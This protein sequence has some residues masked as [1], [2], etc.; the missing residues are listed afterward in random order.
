MTLE[1][2]DFLCV[3]IGVFFGVALRGAV[4]FSTDLRAAAFFLTATFL[5]G[6]FR[7]AV[8]FTFTDFRDAVFFATARVAF[9]R[10]LATAARL[11]AVGLGAERRATARE[12]E[13]LKLLVA[14]LIGKS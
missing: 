11:F 1:A 6:F 4:F 12:V 7:F 2:S 5:V 13:R 9:G 10:A 14:A 8:A 3:A